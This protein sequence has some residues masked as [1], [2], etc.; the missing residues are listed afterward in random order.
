MALS[1]LKYIDYILFKEIRTPQQ[2]QGFLVMTFN[3]IG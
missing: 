2:K 3:H 1:G